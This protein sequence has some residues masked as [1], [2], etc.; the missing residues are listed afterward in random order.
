MNKY[1]YNELFNLIRIQQEEENKGK[2][3]KQ[4]FGGDFI[5]F[6]NNPTRSNFNNTITNLTSSKKEEIPD[7]I[8]KYTYRSS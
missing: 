4:E 8:S 7:D 3:P 1:S 6:L 2:E 5:R